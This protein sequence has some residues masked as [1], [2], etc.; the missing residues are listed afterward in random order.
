[1]TDD[2]EALARVVHAA[3]RAYAAE[4]GEAAAPAWADA[5]EWQRAA[6]RAAVRFARDNPEADAAAQH[7]AWVA[8]RR[9]AGW[10][11]GPVK[12]PAARTHPALV[13]FA[14]LPDP[15]RRKDALVVAVVRALAGSTGP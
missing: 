1:M 14:E 10:R 6:T 9:A 2:V 13:P 11:P 8:E 4:L 5:P 3:L 7:D 12:D 15:E